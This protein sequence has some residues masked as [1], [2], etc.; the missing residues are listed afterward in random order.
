MLGEIH[1][2]HH[3]FPEHHARIDDLARG[4][5]GF[6]SQIQEHDKLDKQIRGLELRESPIGD[7]EME[8][9]KRH[10]LHLKDQIL[11]RLL[12]GA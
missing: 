2:I 12:N 8:A 9:L 3:E 1:S 10:R 5:P 11:K 4:D 6:R 7:D